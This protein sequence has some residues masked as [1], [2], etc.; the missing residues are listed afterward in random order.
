MRRPWPW[1]YTALLP[2]EIENTLQRELAVRR[3]GP[4]GCG[5]S[6]R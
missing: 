1:P 2:Y 4:P 5:I 3:S 6:P